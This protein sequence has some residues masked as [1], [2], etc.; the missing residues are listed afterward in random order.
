MLHN[1]TRLF[2]AGLAMAAAVGFAALMPAAA[3]EAASDRPLFIALGTP[4]RAPIGWIDF[5][6]EHAR[7]CDNR[8]VEARDVVLTQK[9][10]KDLV[11]IN[12][13]FNDNIKPIT[14]MDHWGVVERC[15]Y[16]FD[17]SGNC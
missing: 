15:S 5:C 7:E 16:P 10:W 4:A 9:S 14:D 12:R 2:G 1:S 8:T 17:G 3:A 6:A 11:R 13:W